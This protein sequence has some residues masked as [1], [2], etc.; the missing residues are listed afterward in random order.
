M[1]AAKFLPVLDLSGEVEELRGAL[2]AACGRVLDSNAFILGAEVQAFEAAAA[3]YLGVKH[4]VGVNSG[5]DALVLGLRAL[6]IGPGDEVITTGFSFFATAGSIETVGARAVFVDIDADTF[7]IDPNC[8]EARI[9]PSTRA[10]MPVHLYGQAAP[11]QAIRD[12]AERHDLK[13][14][15]DAAQAFGGEYRGRKLGSIG[16]VG[17][18][19]FYPTKNLGACGDAGL[20]VTN[21]DQVAQ[22]ARKLRDHGSERKY[23]HVTL[24]YNSRL[25]AIQAAVLQVKMPYID[26]WNDARRAAARHYRELLGGI[27]GLVLP[28]EADYGRHVYHQYTLRI[29]DGR[30]SAVEEV[31]RAAGIG[32]VIYYPQT[33][34]QAP[35]F[36]ERRGAAAPLPVAEQ[37]CREVLSL[38]MHPRLTEEAQERVAMAL[39]AAMC[40]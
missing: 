34:P 40:A 13:I 20:L 3:D 6:G 24:G 22:L 10:I 4:A 28:H 15:E 21:D 27:E 35:V 7:N 9:T 32:A 12:I 2:L 8:I 26:T 29:E 1:D 5:T 11:M 17:A 31:L 36:A 38:P 14:I 23:H 19:S 18:F 16:D 39:R 33:L 37:A 30:R 25:D